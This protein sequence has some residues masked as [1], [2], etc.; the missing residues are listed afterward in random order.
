M[1]LGFLHVG[2]RQ[3]NQLSSGDWS[4]SRRE[5]AKPE[6][7]SSSHPKKSMLKLLEI[8]TIH[9]RE[10]PTINTNRSRVHNPSIVFAPCQPVFPR[11]RTRRSKHLRAK[12]QHRTMEL[13]G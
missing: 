4:L 13:Q 12:P 11:S 2:P 6:P 9:E 7:P 5:G 8:E 1:A 3:S 10:L